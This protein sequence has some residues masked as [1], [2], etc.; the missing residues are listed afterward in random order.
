M[1]VVSILQ[2]KR[3]NITAVNVEVIGHNPDN[4]PKPYQVIELKFT[5]KGENVDPKAVERAIELSE[6]KYCLVGQS[7]QNEVEIKTTF[8]IEA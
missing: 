1:D 3:Q 8:E 7:L 5:V 4:Y 6:T 2:K